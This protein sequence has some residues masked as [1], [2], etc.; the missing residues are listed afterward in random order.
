MEENDA[1]DTEQALKP[2]AIDE[3][4]ADAA[5]LGHG[6]IVNKL[7]VTT[8]EEFTKL[9]I[10]AKGRIDSQLD[11]VGYDFDPFKICFYI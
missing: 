1:A 5:E 9:D 4:V 7:G 6:A 2:T 10:I 11:V 8:D 3:I